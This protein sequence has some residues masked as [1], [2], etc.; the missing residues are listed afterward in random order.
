MAVFFFRW[1]L[2][3]TS[4]TI[5]SGAV[6]ERA[7]FYAYLGATAWLTGMVYPVVTHAIW[8]GNGWLSSTHQSPLFGVGAIDH[9]GSGVVHMVGAV[10]GL[11]GAIATGPRR[12]RFG[13]DGSPIRIPGHSAPLTLL[14]GYV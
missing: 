6:A 9:A 7:S 11:W 12:G 13:D 4:S 10:C 1:T 5:V 3:A 2:S 8:D 14:G